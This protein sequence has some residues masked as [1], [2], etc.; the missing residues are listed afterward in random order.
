MVR[1][2][3]NSYPSHV[4]LRCIPMSLPSWTLLPTRRRYTSGSDVRSVARG[5]RGDHWRRFRELNLLKAWVARINSCIRGDSGARASLGR[6][7]DEPPSCIRQR[8]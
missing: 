8:P 3:S 1:P 5:A 2:K 7:R 4:P 6:V